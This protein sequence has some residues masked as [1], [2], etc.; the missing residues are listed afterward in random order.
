MSTAQLGGSDSSVVGCR[1]RACG[2]MQYSVVKPLACVRS[3]AV[4]CEREQSASRAC[5]R[6]RVTMRGGRVRLT[7]ESSADEWM[8]GVVAALFATAQRRADRSGSACVRG[9]AWRGVARRVTRPLTHSILASP[10]LV[11]PNGSQPPRRAAGQC[12]TEPTSARTFTAC[13]DF[14]HPTSLNLPS[15]SIQPPHGLP[16]GLECCHP[17]ARLFV[18]TLIPTRPGE[19]EP[20]SI[21]QQLRLSS[22]VQHGHAV[23]AWPCNPPLRL[24]QPRTALSDATT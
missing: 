1:E 8:D 16:G 22:T 10:R 24:L 6:M 5:D 12:S 9:S 17:A 20:R 7:V 19:L 15:P 14:T 3:D 2:T 4:A 11:L 18:T 21:P 23:V 13:F